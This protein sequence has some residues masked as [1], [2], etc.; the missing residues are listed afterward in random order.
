MCSAYFFSL[1]LLSIRFFRDAPKETS[2]MHLHQHDMLKGEQRFLVDY[3]YSFEV[4]QKLWSRYAHA[5]QEFWE[6][7]WYQVL[8]GKL[9]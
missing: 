6:R 3:T 8:T 1:K 9:Q 7:L 4:S 5:L 2:E